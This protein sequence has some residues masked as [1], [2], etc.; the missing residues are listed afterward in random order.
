MDGEL[1]KCWGESFWEYVAAARH[2]ESVTELFIHSVSFSFSGL[3]RKFQSRRKS[4][5]SFLLVT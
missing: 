2:L 5:V 4:A 3:N 1:N